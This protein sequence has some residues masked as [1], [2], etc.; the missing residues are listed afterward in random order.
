MPHEYVQDRI[1]YNQLTPVQ[2][3][4][5]FC[6]AMREEQNQAIKDCMIFLGPLQRP[7]MQSCSVEWSRGRLE[8]G[9][10]SKK[11]KE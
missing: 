3:M 5:V 1:S 11:L 2:W 6:R 8:V 10:K 7:V 9:Q 4:R